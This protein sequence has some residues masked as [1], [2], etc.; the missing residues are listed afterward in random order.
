MRPKRQK[1][2]WL[3]HGEQPRFE[4]FAPCGGWSSCAYHECIHEFGVVLDLVEDD[5]RHHGAHAR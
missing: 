1:G 4:G 5:G 3:R 2:S